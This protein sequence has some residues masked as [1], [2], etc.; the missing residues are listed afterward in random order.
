MKFLLTHLCSCIIC[1]FCVS[2]LSVDHLALA[3]RF[4]KGNPHL[5]NQDKSLFRQL[6][7]AEEEYKDNS[8]KLSL[9]YYLK[10][11]EYERKN[12]IGNAEAA[13]LKALHHN[14]MFIDALSALMRI[15]KQSE[16]LD[17]YNKLL[18][19]TI[20][21]VKEE[22]SMIEEKEFFKNYILSDDHFRYAVQYALIPSVYNEKSIH[23]TMSHNSIKTNL[24]KLLQKLLSE[25][26]TAG[27]K[28]HMEHPK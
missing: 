10:G 2:C 27:A 15:K 20:Y 3:L 28:K 14:S 16:D 4:Y 23:M 9:I 17:G 6:D 22:I 12:N 18:E 21:I 19:K 26:K 11:L 24:E 8:I 1:L 7:M 5:K 25:A 13:Y